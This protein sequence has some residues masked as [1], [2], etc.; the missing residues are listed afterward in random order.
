MSGFAV[1][2]MKSKKKRRNRQVAARPA[3]TPAPV[4]AATERRTRSRALLALAGLVCAAGGVL[5]AAWLWS[6][7][8]GAA[9]LP[10]LPRALA[11]ADADPLIAKAVGDAR[12]LVTDHPRVADAWGHLGRVLLAHA[13]NAEAVD[14][15]AKAEHLDP[16]DPRWPYLSAEA[17]VGED[18]DRAVPKLRRAVELLRDGD[19]DVPRVRLAEAL[20]ERG[21]LDE[22]ESLLRRAHERN[23]DDAR[24]L[25]AL[26]QLEVTRGRFEAAR[27]ALERAAAR[28]PDVQRPYALLAMTY[29]RLGE[30]TKARDANERARRLSPAT[31]WPDPWMAEVTKL[32][33]GLESILEQATTRLKRGEPD[34]A[35]ALLRV[36]TRHYPKSAEA[37]R[38]TGIALMQT[39]DPREAE[40]A[41]RTAVGL[42]PR[43]DAQVMLAYLLARTGRQDE[44]EAAARA[45]IASH[46]THGEAHF[47]LALA[48]RGQG[49]ADEVIAALREAVRHQPD[50]TA[51][52][53][54]LADALEAAGQHEQAVEVLRAALSTPADEKAIR[55]RLAM[56]EGAR[57]TSPA[58]AQPR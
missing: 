41:L 53:V 57:S 49:R 23:P 58:S 36:A 25:L 18:P 4:R 6:A 27:D 46:P 29:A 17:V 31:S 15:F 1:G 8:P 44:A 54:G 21:D 2:A 3:P 26:G 50:L 55:Q 51:A 35:A 42:D 13:F 7:R 40:R 12:Q 19:P 20:L 16:A 45:A 38:Q 5:I 37:W 30:P 22:A 28:A 14:A 9:A 52:H 24:V 48:L 34:R 56:L 47:T 43:N 39:G 11:A 33:T 32:Q 10:P